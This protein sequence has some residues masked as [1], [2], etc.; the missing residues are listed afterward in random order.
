MLHNNATLNNKKLTAYDFVFA[1]LFSFVVVELIV[2]LMV[3]VVV[4]S[5]DFSGFKC[6]I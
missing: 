1:Q 6:Q 4:M 5:N 3:L 2:P